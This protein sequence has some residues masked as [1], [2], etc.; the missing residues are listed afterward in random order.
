MLGDCLREWDV[1]GGGV[2]KGKI[3]TTIVEYQLKMYLLKTNYIN[4][5][6]I[7]YIKNKY[8]KHHFLKIFQ[9]AK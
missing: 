5:K 6:Y 1:L 2:P 8:T 9:V 4:I 3:K 7:N